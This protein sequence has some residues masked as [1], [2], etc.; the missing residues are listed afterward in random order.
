MEYE[1]GW[2]DHPIFFDLNYNRHHSSFCLTAALLA[3]A[4]LLCCLEAGAQESSVQQDSLLRDDIRAYTARALKDRV[5]TKDKSDSILA[6][7][8]DSLPTAQ[9]LRITVLM[10]IRD[11]IDNLYDEYVTKL[12]EMTSY[13]YNYIASS[14]LPSLLH[15]PEGIRDPLK[16]RSAREFAAASR[17]KSDMVRQFESEK[18]NIPKWAVFILQFLFNAGMDTTGKSMAIHQGLYYIPIPG[19]QPPPEPWAKSVPKATD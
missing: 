16:E 7:I 12:D 18:L 6:V 15:E 11:E 2:C 14:M 9:D 8:Q 1:I 17:I 3:V 19:G 4:G 13:D 5:I 10:D